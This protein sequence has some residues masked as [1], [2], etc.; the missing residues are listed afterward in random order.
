MSRTNDGIPGLSRPG[1]VQQQRIAQAWR[2]G[3]SAQKLR[4]RQLILMG[5]A[6]V[7]GLLRAAAGDAGAGIA[8]GVV[9]LVVFSPMLLMWNSQ[10]SRINK[11]GA[12]LDA[13]QFLVTEAEGEQ[14]VTNRWSRHYVGV[15]RA[16]L[17]DGTVL[18]S[19]EIPYN[20]AA[21][22]GSRSGA[23]QAWLVLIEGEDKPII[24]RR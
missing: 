11:R 15:A 22:M 14:A 19:V 13:G 21:Q 12:K 6:V 18:R 3:T 24:F 1:Q 9:L 23:F 7:M 8:S 5:I 16:R 2:Q 17:A 20:Q 10:I 4:R